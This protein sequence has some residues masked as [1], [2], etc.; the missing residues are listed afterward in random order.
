M[1]LGG[2]GDPSRALAFDIGS[3]A[4]LD[5][6]LGTNCTEEWLDGGIKRTRAH[7]SDY[8][9]ALVVNFLEIAN[10]TSF[11]KAT[12]PMVKDLP[13]QEDFDAPGMFEKDCVSFLGA[14]LWIARCCRPEDSFAVGFVARISAKWIRAATRPGD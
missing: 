4:S 9:R 3:C 2:A 13:C 7:L 1:G 6:Y 8:T 10:K 14:L 12:T 5:R 11:R